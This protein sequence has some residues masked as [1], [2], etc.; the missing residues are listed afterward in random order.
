[1]ERD[2]HLYQVEEIDNSEEPEEDDNIVFAEP[3]GSHIDH[4]RNQYQPRGSTTEVIPCSQFHIEG[5]IIMTNA[6]TEIF[7][8]LNTFKET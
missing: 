4:T 1:M 3:R 8:E 5:Y 7:D 6:L 2:L